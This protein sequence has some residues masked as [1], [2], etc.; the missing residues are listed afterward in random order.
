MLPKSG[1]D[2][3]FRDGGGGNGTDDGGG[4]GGGG[5]SRDRARGVDRVSAPSVRTNLS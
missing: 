3:K 5:R 1:T 4:I 2:G